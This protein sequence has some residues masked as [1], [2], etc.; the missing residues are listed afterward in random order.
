LQ[1]A[2]CGLLNLEFQI[3]NFGFK[4]R[5]PNSGFRNK[6]M[7]RYSIGSIVGILLLWELL[8]RWLEI[9]KFLLPTPLTI[10]SYMIAKSRLLASH[11]TM[12]LLESGVGFI[13]GSFSAI[14]TAIL[15]L[16]SRPLKEMFYPYAVIL[17]STPIVA[18][19]A[20]I[21]IIFGS[22]MW[23]KVITAI[24][25]VF[26]P[27]LGPTFK[28]LA[29]VGA[30]EMKWM[31]S[32][33]SSRWQKFWHLQFPFALPQMFASFKVAWTLAVIGAV[34]GEVFGAYRG[35]GFLIVDAIYI[36]DTPRVFASI[37]ACSLLGLSFVGVITLIEKRAIAWHI[38][39]ER[40]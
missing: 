27:V 36:M 35:L 12:T 3:F 22:G 8:V 13:I 20:P 21:V 28:A 39:A 24:I 23:S 7:N 11:T 26:F 9:P 1:I 25:C 14:L 17:N 2:E 15:F 10:V 37:I 31:D 40:R 5:N 38:S 34:V 29:S 33:C 16:W 19:A 4:F 30:S 32:Y 6:K 18:I